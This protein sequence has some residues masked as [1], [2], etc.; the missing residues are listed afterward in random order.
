MLKCSLAFFVSV[1]AIEP[2]KESENPKY[3][4][5]VSYEDYH[6]PFMTKIS[7]P[8]KEGQTVH[9]IGKISK[10]PKRHFN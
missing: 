9:A 6:L 5:Y 7:E 3:L 1:N 8:F 4:P 2:I 10:N